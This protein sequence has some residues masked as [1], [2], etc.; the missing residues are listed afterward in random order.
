MNSPKL[1]ATQNEIELREESKSNNYYTAWY[2]IQELRRRGLDASTYNTVVS[3][4]SLR[5]GGR[6][7]GTYAGPDDHGIEPICVTTTERT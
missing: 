6:S 4:S 1:A 2:A 3:E 7:D 5:G